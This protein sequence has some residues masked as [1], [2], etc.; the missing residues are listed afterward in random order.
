[1]NNNSPNWHQNILIKLAKRFL[2]RISIGQLTLILPDKTEFVF[3]S[4]L[5]GRIAQIKVKNYSFFRKFVFEGAVGFGESYCD[6]DWET[7]D[8]TNLI[9]LFIENRPGISESQ[10]GL[11]WISRTVN[12]FL[13]KFRRNSPHG[14]KKNIEAHYDLSNKFFSLV[15]DPT[16]SYSCAMYEGSDESLEEAQKRKISH[17]IS[18]LKIGREQHVLEIGSGWGS[19][20]LEAAKL[21]S[22]VVTSLTLSE[23]QLKYATQKASDQGLS[24]KV[25][26]KLCDYRDAEGQYDRIVSVEML[27]AVG[28]EYLGDF[29]AS[30]ERLLKPDGL[31][32]LQV[33]CIPDQRYDQYSRSCDWIKKHIFPG[34]CLPSLTALSKAMQDNSS[35][36]VESLK[37]IGPNYAPT[38]AAWR[39]ALLSRTQDIRTLGFDDYFIRS[40]EY[41]F[42]YCEAAFATRTLNVLQLV[43][44]RPGNSTLIKE[45]VLNAAINKHQ[46]IKMTA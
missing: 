24:H 26:F 46:V 33:I 13:H 29:F 7:D 20:A 35:L 38:L 17:L 3:G 1:M 27:E 31:V 41:Y 5:R 9:A 11:A 12:Y 14:S 32:V 21:Q 19:L 6:G 2:Q 15:L 42:S 8:L 10:L 25:E 37:N 40:F 23:E 28:D 30:C 44:T 18:E 4:S 22:C 16:K 36:I 39:E 34:C 43:L 45:D